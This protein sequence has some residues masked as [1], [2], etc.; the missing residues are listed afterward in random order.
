MFAPAPQPELIVCDRRAAVVER[1]RWK[2]EQSGISIRSGHRSSE[3][4]GVCGT[5]E[6]SNSI[7]INSSH[8][9]LNLLEEKS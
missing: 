7:E 4:G 8:L 1:E 9:F 3:L 6:I 2:K 5:G